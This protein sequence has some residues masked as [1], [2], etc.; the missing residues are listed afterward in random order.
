MAWLPGEEVRSLAKEAL[1]SPHVPSASGL[2][3]R[4]LIRA[5]SSPSEVVPKPL[6]Q[7]PWMAPLPLSLEKVGWNSHQEGNKQ[8]HPPDQDPKGKIQL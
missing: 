8:E 2:Q 6:P 1:P 4:L 5:H 7:G 3:R